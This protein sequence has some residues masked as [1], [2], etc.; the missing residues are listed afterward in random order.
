MGTLYSRFKV[1]HYADDLAVLPYAQKEIRPPVSLRIKPTNVCNHNCR[2]CAYRVDGLQLGKD[3]VESDHIPKEKLFEII[4]D[5]NEMGVRSIT[6]SGGGDPFCYPHFEET[7]VKLAGTDIQFAALTNGSRLKDGVADIFAQSGTWVRISIDGWDGPSYAAYRGVSE[8]AFGNV[9]A[10][11]ERFSKKKRRCYLG[12]AIV[13]D[14]MNCNRI[15]DL[16]KV[17]KESGADSVKISPVITS[18]TGRETNVYHRRIEAQVRDQIARVQAE[19]KGSDFEV[20]DS[21]HLQLETFQKSYDWCPYIQL[22]PVIG[23]D[24]ALYS[25]HDK[26]YNHDS[27][28]IGDLSTARFKEVWFSQKERF[29]GIHPNRDCGHHC[30]VNG[31]N[32]MIHEFLQI[33]PLHKMFI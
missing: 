32:E 16:S 26:A 8:K 4:D 2:Y 27:G 9:T 17:L 18:N 28:R 19:L 21:Y 6:F 12:T 1:F 5:A 7:L 10:N 11:I 24:S 20:F 31:A 22:C 30:V 15:Y 29:F 25:C 23:A 14:E 3:M 13:V 33:D